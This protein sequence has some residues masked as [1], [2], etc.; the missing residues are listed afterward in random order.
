MGSLGDTNHPVAIWQ[1]LHLLLPQPH[2]WRAHLD[3]VPALVQATLDLVTI[4][5]LRQPALGVV[6]QAAGIGEESGGPQSTQVQEAFL[7]IA[8]EL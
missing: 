5:E 3:E 4:Q 1:H 6:H 7:G 2:P 8:G